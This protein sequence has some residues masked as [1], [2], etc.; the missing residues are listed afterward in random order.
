MPSSLQGGP[1]AQQQHKM[2]T[3][4]WQA[5]APATPYSPCIAIPCAA[6]HACLCCREL[7]GTGVA[8]TI[9]ARPSSPTAA[10]QAGSDM[11][12]PGAYYNPA[13]EAA[14][15]SSKAFSFG[16]RLAAPAGAAAGADSPGPASYA[17]PEDKGGPAYTIGGRLQRAGTVIVP[18]GP[19]RFWSRVRLEMLLQMPTYVQPASGCVMARNHESLTICLCHLCCCFCCFCCCCCCIYCRCY[20]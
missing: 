4:T 2:Q 16:A 19:H 12:G 20:Q 14:L 5:Q 18:H 9:A 6:C 1:A 15:Q 3:A 7:P 13:A 10:H 11:A 8:F 17:V